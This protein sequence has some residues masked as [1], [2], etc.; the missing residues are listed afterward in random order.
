MTKKPGKQLNLWRAQA[1]AVHAA[2]S[3]G[4]LMRRQLHASKRANSVTQHDIKLELD[5]RCQGTDREGP[6]AELSLCG[7][8]G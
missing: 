2:Q 8:R 4:A 3:V 7:P 1:A 5:V 6:E